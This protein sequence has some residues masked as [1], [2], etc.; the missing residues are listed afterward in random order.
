MLEII[1]N[2]VIGIIKKDNCYFSLMVLIL[3]FLLF[4]YKLTHWGSIF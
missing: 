1:C 3:H 4:N 2:N